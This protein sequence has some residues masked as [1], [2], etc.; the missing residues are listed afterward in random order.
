MQQSKKI[1]III[2]FIFFVIFTETNKINFIIQ[3]VLN[4]FVAFLM[5][6][7]S[8]CWL[9]VVTDNRATTVLF[10]L[11]VPTSDYVPSKWFFSRHLKTSLLPS[12]RVSG[13]RNWKTPVPVRLSIPFFLEPQGSSFSWQYILRHLRWEQ[14]SNRIRNLKRSE[15]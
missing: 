10:L 9:E 4:F 14:I 6:D 1:Y 13:S 2:L 8:R 7:S 5:I 15:K 3:I 11:F 12:V